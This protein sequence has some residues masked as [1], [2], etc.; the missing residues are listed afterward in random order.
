MG[1]DVLLERVINLSEEDKKHIEDFK[2]Y[3]LCDTEGNFKDRGFPEWALNAKVQ[4]NDEFY[5]W[6]SMGDELDI[7]FDDYHCEAISTDYDGTTMT[8]VK[9]NDSS[10]RFEI[11]A[12]DVPTF[13]KDIFV[14]CYESKNSIRK[15]FNSKFY[16]DYDE[17]KT[18]V[19][20]WTKAELIEYFNKYI[21]SSE[22]VKNEFTE[23]IINNF[24][25]GEDLV[26]ISW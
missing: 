20:L 24:V 11:N 10:D 1:L 18:Q 16:D 21:K 25:E 3:Y 17:G 4:I 19:I 23:K 12:D 5:D 6:K 7:N 9:N 2:Y 13:R 8:F 22:E 15:P 26:Y 14:V